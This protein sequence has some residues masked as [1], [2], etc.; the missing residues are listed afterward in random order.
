MND[1]RDRNGWTAVDAVLWIAAIG[2]VVATLVF[3]LGPPP[4]VL[5][6]FPYADKVFHALGYGAMTL[7]WLLA[8]VWRP[9][10]PAGDVSKQLKEAVAIVAAAILFGSVVEIAQHFA[11]RDADVLDALADTV[12]ALAGLIAW[13]TMRTIARPAM[14][15]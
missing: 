9:G 1:P 13:T 15:V 14:R 12:G 7:T 10:R 8:A 2:F 4:A 5:P 3:S 11:D 6:N